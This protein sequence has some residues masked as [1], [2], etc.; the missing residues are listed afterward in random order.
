MQPYARHPRYRKIYQL[1]E[2][3][4][5]AHPAAGSRQVALE[6]AKT[7]IH[8]FM[9]SALPYSKKVPSDAHDVLDLWKY[10][11]ELQQI[12]NQGSASPLG[13]ATEAPAGP[14]MKLIVLANRIDNGSA[15]RLAS[16]QPKS[17]PA[18]RA[19]LGFDAANSVR[20]SSSETVP[21]IAP[22]HDSTSLGKARPHGDI[23]SHGS[24]KPTKAN[25]RCKLCDHPLTVD[26]PVQ[27]SKY[28][29]SK[30]NRTN[31]PSP[32]WHTVST[33]CSSSTLST[34]NELRV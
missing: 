5:A 23:F 11:H 2:E 29:G 13:V 12:S 26:S 21:H 8:H 19:S 17:I 20:S 7:R 24:L 34:Y 9:R 3:L 32:N 33:V 31:P 14:W 18:A 30:G 1:I 28:Q 25:I 16:N 27:T 4:Q 6:M 22:D 15:P 10:L